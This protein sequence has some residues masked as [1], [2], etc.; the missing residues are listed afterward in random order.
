MVLIHVCAGSNP[1]GAVHEALCLEIIYKPSCFWVGCRIKRVHHLK[2]NSYDPR[3]G[4]LGEV[5]L[6]GLESNPLKL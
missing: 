5:T 6:S 2:S 4:F 3:D 1:A